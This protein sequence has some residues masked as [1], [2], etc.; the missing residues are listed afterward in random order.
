M[1]TSMPLPVAV[2]QESHL[3]VGIMGGWGAGPCSYSYASHL[4]RLQC[5]S[6]CC[7]NLSYPILSVE[8]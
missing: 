2:K 6:K 1:T 3:R 5:C 4:M 7:G 8:I